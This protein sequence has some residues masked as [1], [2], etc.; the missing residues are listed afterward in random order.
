MA[1]SRIPSSSRLPPLQ[2]SDS[3]RP[4]AGG[5]LVSEVFRP[6]YPWDPF[7]RLHTIRE[8]WMLKLENVVAATSEVR[9]DVVLVLGA[10]K[11]RDISPIFQSPQLASSLLIIASHQPPTIQEPTLSVLP[12]ICILRLNTPLAVEANGAVR[13]VTVLECAERVS[14]IW[15]KNGGPGIRE[16]R[17]SKT[18]LHP[19]AIPY[20]L[21]KVLDSGSASPSPLSSNEGL[22]NSRPSSFI[23]TSRSIVGSRSRRS[24]TAQLPAADPSQRPLD[25]ILN[26]LPHGLVDRAS[27]KQSILVT[28]L[29]RPYLV[30]LCP[31]SS[32]QLTSKPSESRRS[33]F[34]RRSVLHDSPSPPTLGSRDS[35]ETNSTHLSFPTSTP[36]TTSRLLHILAHSGKSHVEQEKLIHNMESFQLSFSQPPSLGMKQPDALETA[37]AY[38]VPV[39]AL[40]EVVCYAPP[41]TPFTSS[42]AERRAATAEWTV[43]DL[44]LSGVLD[45]LSNPG[46][47]P[48]TGPRAWISSAAD[49]SF[50]PETG[51]G[52]AFSPLPPTPLSSTSSP[53]VRERRRDSDVPW[54]LGQTSDNYS[55]FNGPQ[56]LAKPPRVPPKVKRRPVPQM[57]TEI[58]T[59]SSSSEDSALESEHG[60]EPTIIT[61]MDRSR[62]TGEDKGVV[63]GKRLWWRFGSTTNRTVTR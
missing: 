34:L 37:T 20:N 21:F 14:R 50:T 17:E 26:F 4:R 56:G 19:D 18:G 42:R 35:L 52:P 55:S 12:A 41:Q 29:S 48:Y 3:P 61:A 47:A 44:V 38:L 11:L 7:A 10:P 33:S 8:P 62:V 15:R 23:S 16:I 32:S 49:F 40:R 6:K 36:L 53:R 58:P 25:V 39:T 27:L 31:A 51:M 46:Q 30:A 57:F 54:N 63:V 24:S 9:R 60:V 2:R 59:P 28:T 45:P 43:A 13:L 5:S 1:S 22:E